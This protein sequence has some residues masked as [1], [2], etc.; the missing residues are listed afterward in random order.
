MK[1]LLKFLFVFVIALF[2]FAS[3][4]AQILMAAPLKAETLTLTLSSPDVAFTQEY[5]KTAAAQTTTVTI[6]ATAYWKLSVT[7][8]TTQFTSV[9]TNDKFALNKV[10]LTGLVS[11]TFGGLCEASGFKDKSSTIYWNLG[12][13][14]NIYAGQYSAPV[15]FTLIK[16]NK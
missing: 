6:Q 3:A 1:R 12:D 2:A 16:D 11:G 7:T 5:G 4:N 15:T 10:T 8:T 13:I 9:T 14:E